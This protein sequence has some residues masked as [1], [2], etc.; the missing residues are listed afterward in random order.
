MLKIKAINNLTKSY[1]FLVLFFVSVSYG[2]EKV[3]D[4]T[5]HDFRKNFTAFYLAKTAET[6]LF[7]KN[8]ADRK[9]RK[10]IETI[11]LE[12]KTT[13][14]DQIKKGVFINDKRYTDL[15]DSLFVKIKKAN[16]QIHNIKLVYA[17]GNES[18][19]YNFGEDIVVIYLKLLQAFENEYQLG[20]V[21]CHEIAHQ[22]LNHTKTS[23]L[24]RVETNLS[25]QVRKTTRTI[26]S[27]R[28]NK[29]EKAR[30]A[31]KKMVYGDRAESR[32]KEI[33]ADSL[34]F[35]YFNN[36]F[37]THGKQAIAALK[38][39]DEID[40]EKDSVTEKDFENFFTSSRQPFKKEWVTNTEFDNYQYEKAIKFWQVDSLKTH[41]DCL[42][43]IEALK[44]YAQK[45]DDEVVLS[46]LEYQNLKK[47]TTYDVVL[48]LHF[49]KD[50]GNSLYQT[51]LLLKKEPDNR[52]LKSM[53]YNNLIK[54]Q[55]A[56]NNYVLGK[57][58][59]NLDPKRSTSYNRLLFFIRKLKKAELENIIEIY[60]Q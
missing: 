39:L 20:F 35:V 45:S 36:A 19:A 3:I 22:M 25:D 49:S 33:Q 23:L 2:Q 55:E 51:L 14:L 10:E 48:G 17:L 32:K 27:Q 58:L 54:I 50:Y 7:I 43:R 46:T 29:G 15:A 12:N 5:N 30:S 34:G 1:S 28:F 59:D 38:L 16:P 47:A 42:D 24:K 31:L 13:F 40:V 53:V 9:V 60:K 21:I 11:C 41:P 52:F 4:T 56:Q 6:D 37:K 44:K 18:N 8:I 57:Y 26:D